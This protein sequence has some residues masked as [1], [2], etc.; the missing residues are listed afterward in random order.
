MKKY[1]KSMAAKLKVIWSERAVTDL[2][3]I[4]NY[5]LEEWSSKEANAF[6]DLVQEFIRLIVQY[7]NAFAV[8]KKIKACRLGLIHKNVTAVYSVSTNAIH[9]VTLFDNRAKS[10]YR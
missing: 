10:K 1:G 7:P 4:Y 3:L 6:L 9:I 8:S 5:L 2:D